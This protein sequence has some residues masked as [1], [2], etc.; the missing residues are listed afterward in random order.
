[1]Q[2]LSNLSHRRVHAG[3]DIDEHTLAPQQV[4]D[5]TAGDEL[6]PPLDQQDQQVH[7]LAL[8]PNGPPVSPQLVAGDVQ[9]ILAE[10]KRLAW[11]GALHP[12]NHGH[13]VITGL[14]T[15]SYR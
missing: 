15:A 7:R 2:S 11:A 10:A 12:D 5:L 3:F 6:L 14:W 13:N 1:V 4:D 8:D 9:L